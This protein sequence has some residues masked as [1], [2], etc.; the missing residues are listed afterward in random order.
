MREICWWSKVICVR[1]RERERERERRRRRRRKLWR[2]ERVNALKSLISRVLMIWSLFFFFFT[3]RFNRNQQFTNGV[4]LI[5][6][7]KSRE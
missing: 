4:T 2:L 1:E 5:K 6:L 3:I 7:Q